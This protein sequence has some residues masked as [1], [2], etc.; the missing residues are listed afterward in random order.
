MTEASPLPPG[1]RRP[2]AR[3]SAACL[4]GVRVLLDAGADVN[5]RDRSR[6]TV[7]AMARRVTHAELVAMLLSRG[8]RD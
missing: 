7:L 5:G 8:A 3:R 4:A 6:D 2:F 1:P